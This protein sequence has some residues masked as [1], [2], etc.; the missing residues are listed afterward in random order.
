MIKC[1]L[2]L[3]FDKE[4]N[5]KSTIEKIRPWHFRKL[6]TPTREISRYID[7]QTETMYLFHVMKYSSVI[8][9]DKT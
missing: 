1:P 4:N 8:S 7:L 2:Y 6:Y 3:V 5:R 9:G